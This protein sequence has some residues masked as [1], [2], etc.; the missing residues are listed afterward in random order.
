M[1]AIDRS[2]AW[3]VLLFL[4][5]TD[6]GMAGPVTESVRERFGALGRN[7]PGSTA[8]ADITVCTSWMMPS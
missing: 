8:A 6:T 3:Y 1:D 5:M 4:A 7:V 2:G